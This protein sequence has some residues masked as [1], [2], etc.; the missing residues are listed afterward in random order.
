MARDA[1]WSEA[2]AVGTLN[3]IDK[4]KSELGIQ[5]GA[6]AVQ[7]FTNSYIHEKYSA[8]SYTFSFLAVSVIGLSPAFGSQV[9]A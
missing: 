6:A 2:I 9:T 8:L 3:F 5:S 4:L 7:K 1:R